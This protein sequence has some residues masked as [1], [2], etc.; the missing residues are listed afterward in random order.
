MFT[1]KKTEVKVQ[2]LSTID[3]VKLRAYAVVWYAEQN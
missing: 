3:E 1:F 2:G